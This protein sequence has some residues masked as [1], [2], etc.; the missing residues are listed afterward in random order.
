MNLTKPS[1]KDRVYRCMTKVSEIPLR[2][3]RYAM[4][5]IA[6]SHEMGERLTTTKLGMQRYQIFK[7]SVKDRRSAR[8]TT[9][10]PRSRVMRILSV[11]GL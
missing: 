4:H 7:K 2:S 6:L 10:K 3:E 9:G 11:L 5:Q 8:N 1:C